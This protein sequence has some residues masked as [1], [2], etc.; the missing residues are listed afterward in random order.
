MKKAK[1]NTNPR[2]E[3][4]DDLFNLHR[5]GELSLLEEKLKIEIKKFPSSSRLYNLM[6]ASL[7]N[8]N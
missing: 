7:A 5:E 4:F 2:K 3:V 1:Q 6:G 8:Q